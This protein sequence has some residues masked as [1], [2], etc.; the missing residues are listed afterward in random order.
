MH[1]WC[2]INQ[3]F[4]LIRSNIWERGRYII[5]PTNNSNIM[6]LVCSVIPRAPIIFH[7][8]EGFQLEQ[9]PSFPCVFFIVLSS[10]SNGGKTL[11]IYIS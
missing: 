8:G 6:I 9:A 10:C 3:V 2:I 11:S 4:S 5:C 1:V 7:G